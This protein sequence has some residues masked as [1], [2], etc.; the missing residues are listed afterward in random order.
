MHVSGELVPMISCL[1]PP[2]LLTLYYATA[3]PHLS[4]YV[5]IDIWQ[6]HA[7][8]NYINDRFFSLRPGFRVSRNDDLKHQ[9][10]C[11]ENR[12]SRKVVSQNVCFFRVLL[13]YLGL[14]SRLKV[15]QLPVENV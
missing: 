7:I 6:L 13:T 15:S 12:V 1:F 2:T 5:H 4:L 9:L 3:Y 8:G 14:S 10:A 11:L